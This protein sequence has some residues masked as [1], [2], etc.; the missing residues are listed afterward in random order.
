MA[1]SVSGGDTHDD[2]IRLWREEDWWVATDVETGVTSQGPTRETALE[3]LD[4]AVAL[5]EG[6]SG[7]D[8]TDAELR[9]LG[10]D[11]GE[12]TTGDQR[13]PDVLE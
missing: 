3:N 4:D 2:E 10:I 13:P 6:D 12:N 11:P 5:H 1:S 7:S 9:E 8:P